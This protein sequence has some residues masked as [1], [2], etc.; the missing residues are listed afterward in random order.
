MIYFEVNSVRFKFNSIKKSCHFTCLPKFLKREVEL[1]MG[2]LD[3]AY[4]LY[5]AW[6]HHPL[7][8]KAKQ[9]LKTTE[10]ES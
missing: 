4:A 3:N 5:N 7:C 9:E 8:V 10:L 2:S 1:Q 6:G